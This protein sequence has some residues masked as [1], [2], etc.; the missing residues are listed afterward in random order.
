MI[1][2]VRRLWRQQAEIQRQCTEGLGVWGGSP[3]N[4]TPIYHLPHFI[5]PCDRVTIQQS[6][7]LATFYI[8]VLSNEILL[9]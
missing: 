7:R 6:Q 9:F 1:F 2:D 3:V 8:F 4:A 5:G